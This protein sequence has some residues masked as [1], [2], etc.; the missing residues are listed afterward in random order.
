MV[1][2]QRSVRS[3]VVARDLFSR[4][5]AN[6]SFNGRFIRTRLSIFEASD[7]FTERFAQ[8]GELART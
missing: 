7:S 6:P 8:F 2:K 3:C 4:L 1:R 5:S